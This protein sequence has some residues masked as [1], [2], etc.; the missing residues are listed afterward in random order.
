MPV[1]D[2][3]DSQGKLPA[4]GSVGTDELEAETEA[5]SAIRC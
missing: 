5:G 2:K 3:S 4:G 1:A